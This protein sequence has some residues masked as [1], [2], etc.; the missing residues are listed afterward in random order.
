MKDIIIIGAGGHG[1]ELDEFIRY[2]N[3]H[4]EAPKVNLIGYLDDQKESYDRY[5]LSAPF[6]GKIKEHK[7]RKNCEYLIGIADLKYRR[8]IVESFINQGAVFTGYIHPESF[9]SESAD[10]GIGVV[11]AYHCNIGPNTKIGDFTMINA[12]ASIAHDT[13]V[14]DFNFIGPNVCLS[15]FTE[16]G[17]ENLFGINSATIPQIKI[18]NRNKISAGMTLDKNIADDSTVF[19][20]IKERVMA[21]PKR[22]N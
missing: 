6:L 19:Y 20:R 18:G 14:G 3:T 10:I 21:I 4:Q 17:D 5:K 13:Q 11:V 7:V 22:N 12:R 8:K 1:A 15:G 9:V 16:V 2:S